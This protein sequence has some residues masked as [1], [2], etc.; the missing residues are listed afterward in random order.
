M[1][2]NLLALLEGAALNLVAALV[3]VRGIYAR[4]AAEKNYVFSFLAFNTVIFFVLALLTSVELSVGVGFGLFAIFSV[5]RY[6]TEETPIREMT[7]L[8]V[9]IALPVMNA[10]LAPTGALGPLLLAN[11]A[12]VA[13][14]YALER[15]WGFRFTAS[16][17]VTY[18]RIDLIVPER[19]EE[20]LADLR[21]RTGLPIT[22][23]TVGRLDFLR[24]TAEVTVHYDPAALAAGPRR[25]Q[26]E[27]RGRQALP[28]AKSVR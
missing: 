27:E 12:V 18:D 8:F 28:A 6:R 3:I 2:A 14:M 24:D 5:L 26:I 23:A 19:H 9:L 13:V 4:E 11:G 16:S 25:A 1:T 7:Y 21:Q 22:R 10:V 15:G 17:R 20:L